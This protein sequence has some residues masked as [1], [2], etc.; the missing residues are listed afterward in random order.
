MVRYY[1]IKDLDILGKREDY[2]PYLYEKGKGWQMN[3]NNIVMDRLMGYDATESEDSP[4]RFGSMDMLDR[5]SEIT[6][7]SA[8]KIIQKLQQPAN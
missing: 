8:Q 4:Y 2:I 6:E 5:I 1:Y 7:E 3:N